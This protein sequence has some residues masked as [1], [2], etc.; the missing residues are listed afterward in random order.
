M[1]TFCSLLT[2]FFVVVAFFACSTSAS[3]NENLLFTKKTGMVTYACK[4]AYAGKSINIYYHIPDGNIKNMPVQIIMHGMNRNGDKYRDDWKKLADKYGFIVLAPQFSEDEFSKDAYQRG[5]VTNESGAFVSQ[6]LM[7]YPIISEVFHYFIDHSGSQAT[8]YNIYG[9]SAGAQFVHRYLLFNKTP[10]VDR[11]IAANAGWYTFPTDTKDYPYGIGQSASQIGTDVAAYYQKN[12][13][14]L[15][16]TADTLRTESFNQSKKAEAQGHTRLERGKNFFEYCKSNAANRGIPFHWENI[17]VEG[18]GHS[19]SK[20]A[21]HAAKLL[22][23][24]K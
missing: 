7:I 18:V 8:K 1:K 23:G 24:G 16:G 20:M 6:D 9:H 12:L 5:N 11:A 13:I 19:D 4:G 10:E 17:L 2:I 21:P 22:Y 3:D 15:L 14:I